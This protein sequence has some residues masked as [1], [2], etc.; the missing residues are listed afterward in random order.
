MGLGEV[1]VTGK[2]FSVKKAM[3]T[4]VPFCEVL[5][6]APQAACGEVESNGTVYRQ[7][8]N[9]IGNILEHMAINQNNGL[10]TLV[11]FPYVAE[12]VKCSIV[13]FIAGIAY[14]I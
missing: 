9:V 14:C 2:L 12:G 7:E 13:N 11:F 4:G 6:E 5:D 10:S 8:I 1:S 3:K